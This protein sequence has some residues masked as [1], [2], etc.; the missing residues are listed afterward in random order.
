TTGGPT[1]GQ[2]SDICPVAFIPNPVDVSIDN[3]CAY[4]IRQKPVDVFFA[5]GASGVSNRWGLVDE[6]CRLRPDLAYD[7]HG[8]DKIGRLAGQTYY[9]AMER[10]KVGLNLNSGEGDLYASDRMA[11]YV[12]NGLLLATQRASGYRRYFNDDEMI[13]FDDAPELGDRLAHVLADDRRW[14]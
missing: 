5:S 8:R 2:F 10:A 1:L 12:G 14:R 13:F 6:L 4:A 3:L 7:L 9:A 11:Q